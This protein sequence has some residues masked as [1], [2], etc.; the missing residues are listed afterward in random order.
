MRL[1]YEE[2]RANCIP[3][4][5]SLFA[6]VDWPY[7]RVWTE[8]SGVEPYRVR[9]KDHATPVH[10]SY[11]AATIDFELQG[12]AT[13]GDFIELAW[14]DQHF[15][16]QLT[17][18]DTLP[19]AAAALTAI[20]NANTGA[21]GVSATVA[22][23]RI[24]LSYDASAGTNANRI[25]VYGTVHG[26]GTESWSP[27]AGVF[28]GGTSPDR[29][30]IELDFGQLVDV[31]GVTVPTTN[32]RKMR[33][34]WAA[35]LQAASYV[36][37]EFAASVTNWSVSGTGLEYRV[38]GPGSRRIE[39]DAPEVSYQGSWTEARGNYSGGSI[40]W[41]ASTGASVACTYSASVTHLL[42]LGTRRADS[43]A[44]I[45]ARVDGGAAMPLGLHLAGED[46]LVRLPLGQFGAGTHTVTISHTGANGT[47]FYFDFLEIA[48]PT[49][50]LPQF[51]VMAKTTLATDWDTDHSIA[52]APERTAWL[53][54]KLGFR[55]RANHYVGAMWFYEFSR[56]GHAYATATLTFAGTPEFGKVTQVSLGATVIS[57]VSLIG[58]TAATVANGLAMLVN[59]GSTGA[60]ATAAGTV[61]TITSRT[62]GVAGNGITV[63]AN[64]SSSAFTATSSG[65]TAGG[66][67]GKWR[68]DL[69]AMPRINRA[70]RDWSAAYF[71][72]LITYG[73]DATAAFSM[74]LQHGDE[75]PTAG[76]AQRYADGAPVLLNTP[77]LQT[78]FGPEST[79]YW[80]QVYDDMAVTMASAGMQPYLQFGEVQWWYFANSA[81]MPF[82]DAYTSGSFLAQYG[83]P[84][85]V[86]ANEHA[87]PGA[88][89]E[90]CTWLRGLV[91]QFTDTVTTYV[92]QNHPA[93]RFEVLYPPDVNDT[94]LNTAVNFPRTSWT[95]SALECLKTENFTYTGNRDM[96]KARSSVMLPME[97]GFPPGKSSHLVGIGE[98]TTP[99]AREQRMAEGQGLDSVVLF[100]LDQFCLIGYRLPLAQT[101]RRALFQ[102]S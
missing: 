43:G 49:V 101:R 40:R 88:F 97:L 29:W 2:T 18:G 74:E 20:I 90:E 84:I 17:A 64:T 33:W 8:S 30:R 60:W 54:Q 13:G 96:D 28:S 83:R 41:S 76:I 38:A 94:A 24:T 80:R 95:P 75:G 62:Q 78:N 35:D 66:S 14:L 87:D 6:T 68:T 71:A 16:Y 32:V 36:R 102:G 15:N 81:S 55:G 11:G 27:A 39:D 50:D 34:T 48:V 72:A 22:A 9:I 100:A 82:Y 10:G 31:N 52:L 79:A 12:T 93:T 47:Y 19:T 4:D 67:D 53:I 21:S 59:A 69:V 25:G 46:V 99:W 51:S 57:H 86:V 26:S 85:R 37:G 65:A 42:L 56:P 44:A 58:D 7:L 70:A 92:R 98:Y 3:I 45:T 23:A 77:A 91:G 73:I 1:S 61:L 89:T 63:S 5:S